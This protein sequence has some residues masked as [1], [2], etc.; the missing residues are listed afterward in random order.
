MPSLPRQNPFAAAVF[1]R[2]GAALLGLLFAGCATVDE[3][4][5]VAAPETPVVAE[6]PPAPET[7]RVETAAPA[8][9]PPPK[10]G[11]WVA[12]YKA[13]SVLATVDG[14]TVY[15]ADP[16]KGNWKTKK[17][18]PTDRDQRKTIDPLFHARTTP[19][20]PNG[21]K[22][23]VCLDPGHGGDDPGALSKDRWT[24]EKT[25]TLDIANRVKRMLEEDGSFEVLTTRTSDRSTLVLSERPLR[26]FR[27]KA[28]AFVSIHLNA[29]PSPSA[30]GIETYVVPSLYM[31]S[32]GYAGAQPRP[33]SKLLYPGNAQ[34]EGNMQ[35]G[36]CIQRRLLRSTR[37]ADR[38]L[39]RARFVVLREACCP[40]ALVECGF[41]TSPGDLSFLRTESGREKIARGIYEGICDF[42]FGTMA[43][44][45]PARSVPAKG[46]APVPATP[47]EN[48]PAEFV[49]GSLRPT[50]NRPISQT[51]P[52]PPSSAAPLE[53]PVPAPPGQPLDP[54]TAAAREA[55]ARAAGLIP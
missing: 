26:A 24:K 20:V 44:G 43:P 1:R 8:I 54:A 32:T 13:G 28:D 49:F 18:S 29:N 25:L 45:L 16:A 46:A 31:E 11:P 42:A 55:A 39:R 37:K 40:A 38:G 48:T 47:T 15:L 21:R 3:T 23:R 36:F 22:F 53:A 10:G 30:H 14:V 34:D 2:A 35:L 19:L 27:W 50:P 17:V 4:T 6:T 52:A 33:E 5:V 41:I 12:T 51:D 7:N 9:P